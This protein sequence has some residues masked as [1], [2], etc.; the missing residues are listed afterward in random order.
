MYHSSHVVA[1]NYNLGTS[2]GNTTPQQGTMGRYDNMLRGSEPN[3]PE[4]NNA[5]YMESAK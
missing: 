3:F 4:N 5:G 2:T 1:V